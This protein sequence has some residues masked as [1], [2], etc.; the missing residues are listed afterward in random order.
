MRK[1]F[2]QKSKQK[3]HQH[4]TLSTT[5]T[6]LTST[7]LSSPVVSSS[8]FNKDDEIQITSTTKKNQ[9]P[10]TSNYFQTITSAQFETNPT[11]ILTM[12]SISNESEIKKANQL[13]Q[14]DNTDKPKKLFVVV[15]GKNKEK[16]KN[17]TIH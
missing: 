7:G 11:D 13:K 4:Q 12:N 9:I 14:D 16:Q 10:E 5:V 17:Q 8:S 1:F 2:G 15:S 6:T 3:A